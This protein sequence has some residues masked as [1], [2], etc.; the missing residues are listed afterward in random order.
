VTSEMDWTVKCFH[1]H[2]GVWK[3]RA[4]EAN[5]PG[6]VAYGWKQS[7]TWGKWARTAENTFRGLKD[8]GN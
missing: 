7:Q 3:Q 2:E 1:H 6:H 5:G 8:A 4:Q